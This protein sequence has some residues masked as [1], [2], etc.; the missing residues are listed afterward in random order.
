MKTMQ[1]PTS[2][3][4]WQV[5][6][7]KASLFAQLFLDFPENTLFDL[8]AWMDMVQGSAAITPR[9]ARLLAMTRGFAGRG[10]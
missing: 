9:A 2:W 10:Q 1:G 5:Q 3:K 7:Q 8:G 6:Q 4:L